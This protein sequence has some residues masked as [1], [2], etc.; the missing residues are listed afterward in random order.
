M[1]QK[2]KT[3]AK[4]QFPKVTS[5]NNSLIQ[6]ESKKISN[7]FNIKNLLDIKG[8]IVFATDYD[9]KKMREAR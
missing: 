5:D 2:K 9:Y 1:L 6:L 8:K 4:K 3:S 7:S